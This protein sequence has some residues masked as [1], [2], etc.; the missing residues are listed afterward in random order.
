MSDN[1]FSEMN[2]PNPIKNLRVGSGTHAEQTAK[3][4]LKLDGIFSDICPK[5]VL[6]YGDTNSTLAAA[7]TACKFNIPICHIEAGLRSFNKSMPEEH[8]RVLTDHCSSLLFCPTSTAMDNLQAENIKQN[9][10]FVGD[11]MYDAVLAFTPHA[12]HKSKIVNE[13]NLKTEKFIL[14]TIHRPYNTDER[15][16]LERL[17]KGAL[18]ARIQS[19]TPNSPKT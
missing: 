6:V 14:A 2:I 17:L 11:T 10:H 13:L 9:V 8:N 12:L 7:L 4:M 15:E 3:I 16:V 5:I 19:I 18:K 1:F